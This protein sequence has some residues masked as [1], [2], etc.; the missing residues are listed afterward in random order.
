MDVGC[1]A[2]PVLEGEG[3]LVVGELGW[4]LADAKNR[5]RWWG[6]YHRVCEGCRHGDNHPPHEADEEIPGLTADE[7]A[8]EFA[9]ELGYVETDERAEDEEYSMAYEKPQL[10]ASPSRNHDPQ[11]PQ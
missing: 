10:F 7:V 4:G 1:K 11:Q 9:V 5:R 6:V 2:G 3:A 8:H